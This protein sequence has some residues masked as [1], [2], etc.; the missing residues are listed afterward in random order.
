MRTDGALP[1]VN[2][3]ALPYSHA[4]SLAEEAVKFDADDPRSYDLLAAAYQEG[5]TTD[6]KKKAQDAKARLGTICQDKNRLTRMVDRLRP[7]VLL[8]PGCQ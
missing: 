8:F 3:S 7:N 1:P 6:A 4:A 2:Q 5:G